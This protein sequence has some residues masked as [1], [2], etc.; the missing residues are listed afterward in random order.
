MADDAVTS[1]IREV[2]SVIPAG[3]SWLRPVSGGDGS[4]TDFEVAAASGSGHDI[5]R[6]GTDRAGSRLSELYPGI[7]D[8]PLWQLYLTVLRTGEPAAM[9]GF[10]YEEKRAGV[11]P[12]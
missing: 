8:G 5:Y 1:A 10:R 7:V 11:V 3:C 6:R 9:N 12:T 4:V 2:L